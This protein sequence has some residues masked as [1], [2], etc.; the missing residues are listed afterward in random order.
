[1]SI[2]FPQRAPGMLS[3]GLFLSVHFLYLSQRSFAVP[4]SSLIHAIF[5]F[6]LFTGSLVLFGRYDVL[7]QSLPPCA[8][9]GTLYA[10]WVFRPFMCDV[11]M[12]LSFL[13]L[14]HSFLASASFLLRPILLLL[15]ECG[16]FSPPHLPRMPVS[17]SSWPLAAFCGVRTC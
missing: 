10:P 7:D 17:P 3:W 8:P 13:S 4:S 2:T 5:G 11:L 16:T 12:I 1:M 14:S 9:A 6:E 15:L